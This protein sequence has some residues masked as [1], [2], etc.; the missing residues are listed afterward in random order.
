MSSIAYTVYF[1]E[2]GESSTTMLSLLVM[3]SM[4]LITW[5]SEPGH[6]DPEE[7]ARGI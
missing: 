3:L 6:T 7:A 1:F 2:S 4:K 5:R